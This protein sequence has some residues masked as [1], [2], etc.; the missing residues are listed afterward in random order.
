[1]I[2]PTLVVGAEPEST[3]PQNRFDLYDWDL[4]EVLPWTHLFRGLRLALDPKKIALGALGAVLMS[5]GW[6]SIAR[7]AQSPPPSVPAAKTTNGASPVEDESDRR[8]REAAL[9]RFRALDQARRFPWEVREGTPDVYRSPLVEERGA[10]V[11]A[12][13][14][15][16]FEPIR[17]LTFPVVLMFQ[18]PGLTGVGLLLG[19]WSLLVW[20]LFGG[21]MTR[22]AAVQVAREGQVGALEA[23]RFALSRYLN[24]V[25]APIL[26]FLGV[27]IIVLL[28]MAGGVLTLVPIA[29][30]VMGLLWFLAVAAGVVMAVAILGL[31]LSWPLMYAAISAEA[32]ESFDA[33][34]RAYSYVLGRPWNFLFY[35]TVALLYGGLGMILATTFGFVVVQLSQYAVSWGGTEAHLAALHAHIPTAG[36]WRSNFGPADGVAPTG[37]AS[38]AAYFVGFWISIVLLAIVGYAYSYFWTSSTLIYFLLRRDVDETEFE[39]VFLDEEEEEPFPT[40]APPIGAAVSPANVSPRVEPRAAP[41]SLPII[42]PPR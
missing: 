6:W 5:A 15:L 42:D 13:F 16:V 8:D 10:R 19:A 22:I 35:S 3:M 39:E 25:A 12:S 14:F 20:A 18:R 1:M 34:S 11:P 2:R 31:A 29:D 28:C 27:L 4:R 40:I 32:T 38:I 17:H 26:P 36:G 30:V 24:Y 21:A 23:L 7:L 37:T 41:G 9:A 33:L